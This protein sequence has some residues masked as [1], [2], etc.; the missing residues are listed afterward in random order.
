VRPEDRKRDRVGISAR[1]KAGR[2]G[3][4]DGPGRFRPGKSATSSAH[5]GEGRESGRYQ[6]HHHPRV[7]RLHGRSDR[8]H[9]SRGGAGCAL[10]VAGPLSSLDVRPRNRE[11][12][13]AD[14]IPA[15]YVFV[16]LP[17][18][19]VAVRPWWIGTSNRSS[20]SW[21]STSI[22][23]PFSGLGG[24]PAVAERAGEE[25]GGRTTT[26]GFPLRVVRPVRPADG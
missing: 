10:L 9:G 26:R 23:S 21:E 5:F 22:R 16:R 15:A 7:F 2:R 19:L 18:E 3:R 6:V 24:R 14:G 11:F 4:R 20:C 1:R 13:I 12:S 25:F 8:V 17:P